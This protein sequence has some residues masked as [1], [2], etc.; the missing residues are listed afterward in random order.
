MQAKDK[1]WTDFGIEAF[2]TSPKNS[3]WSEYEESLKYI[4][5]NWDRLLEPEWIPTADDFLHFRVRTSGMFEM[6]VQVRTG[7]KAEAFGVVVTGDRVFDVLG[8]PT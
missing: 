1:I 3:G 5:Q 6:K 2:R 4:C 7:R 8:W